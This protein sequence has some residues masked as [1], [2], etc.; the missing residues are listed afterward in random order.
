MSRCF[1]LPHLLHVYF[2]IGP[3]LATFNYDMVSRYMSYTRNIGGFYN[4]GFQLLVTKGIKIYGEAEFRAY[5][6]ASYD[7]FNLEKN[8]VRFDNSLPG[9]TKDY[10]NN[11]YD[12]SWLRELVTDGIRFGLKFNF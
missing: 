3:S 1:L 11:R 7:E 9:W 10:K 6:V 8:K 12:K 5:S 4:L 2:K